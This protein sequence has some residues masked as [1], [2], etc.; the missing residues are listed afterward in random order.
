MVAWKV[1]A[2]GTPILEGKTVSSSSCIWTQFINA[3]TYSVRRSCR[4]RAIATGQLE[5]TWRGKLGRLLV[6]D[7]VLP[8]VLEPDGV[9]EQTEASKGK[10]APRSRAHD[11]AFLGRAELGDGAVKHV[12]LVEEVHRCGSMRQWCIR[13]EGE[14]DC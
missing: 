14:A 8:V 10:A 1:R 13:R 12:D 3:S 9:D 6:V 4:K 11:G 5:R 7:P 2:K